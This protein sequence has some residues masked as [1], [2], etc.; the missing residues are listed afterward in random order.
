M[1][2]KRLF[3]IFE[4]AQTNDSNRHYIQPHVELG[5]ALSGLLVLSLC[6]TFNASVSFTVPLILSPTC[7][8][9]GQVL[10]MHNCTSFHFHRLHGIKRWL[11]VKNNTNTKKDMCFIA[12]QLRLQ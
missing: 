8:V 1:S 7:P 5:S 3:N 12:H 10:G 4:L 11:F 6:R 2:E 9:Y